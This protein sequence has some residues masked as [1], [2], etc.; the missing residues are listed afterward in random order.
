M[1]S[2]VGAR[3]GGHEQRSGLGSRR[4][5]ASKCGR[6]PTWCALYTSCPDDWPIGH[7]NRSAART[8]TEA[9]SES[10]ERLPRK[11]TRGAPVCI[12]TD[13]GEAVGAAFHKG[14]GSGLGR[15][16]SETGQAHRAVGS[17]A[18]F[19]DESQRQRIGNRTRGAHARGRAQCLGEAENQVQERRP[20][21]QARFR[22][23]RWR[24]G[25]LGGLRVWGW[26][27]EMEME[28]E[29]GG[30]GARRRRLGLDQAPLAV[31][32]AGEARHAR[33]TSGGQRWQRPSSR[34]AAATACIWRAIACQKSR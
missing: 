11:R 19:G 24:D 33:R 12:C 16:G 13:D 14:W 34:Q 3:K 6:S 7:T 18:L 21:A 8:G 5:E 28:V 10:S 32:E 4:C 15:G 29:G 20:A 2:L 1:K 17:T 25:G 30:V 22:V 23:A 9:G 27:E 26:A 31:V